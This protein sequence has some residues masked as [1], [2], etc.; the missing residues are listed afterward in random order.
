MPER[1]GRV[2]VVLSWRIVAPKCDKNKCLNGGTC[3]ADARNNTY[4]CNCPT[5]YVGK[6]CE[7]YEGEYLN[8]HSNNGSAQMLQKLPTRS[9]S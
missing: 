6:H 2:H 5:H 9:F 7:F 8:I 3:V 4:V 1:G